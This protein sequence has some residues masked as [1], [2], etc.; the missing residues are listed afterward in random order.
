ML[1]SGV[2]HEEKSS[3]LE[4]SSWA[5]HRFEQH[6]MTLLSLT[7]ES[8]TLKLST[9]FEKRT[10]LSEGSDVRCLRFKKR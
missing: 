5:Q 2:G 6:G 4:P 3:A 9:L 8:M 1:S 10:P 7:N